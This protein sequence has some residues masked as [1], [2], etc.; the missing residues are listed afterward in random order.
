MNILRY[1]LFYELPPE[2]VRKMVFPRGYRFTKTDAE[3]LSSATKDD[4]KD[5]FASRY[6]G[7]LVG[8]FADIVD[9]EMKLFRFMKMTT[10]QMLS[11][12]P[13]HIG[14]I[15]GYLTLKELEVN[16]LKSIAEGKRHL[17]TEDEIAE[18]LVL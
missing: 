4:Y 15:I 7:R 10:R 11:G 14:T 9:L 18:S 13:F 5:V 12:Q 6:Y 3:V 17:L 2:E 8:E 16:N 1:R